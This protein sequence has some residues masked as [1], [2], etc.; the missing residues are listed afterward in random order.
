MSKEKWKTEM[1]RTPFQ[2]ALWNPHECWQLKIM[3][4]AFDFSIPVYINQSKGQFRSESAH[5]PL[6]QPSAISL[7][8]G[9]WANL[10]VSPGEV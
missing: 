9:L 4:D 7:S 2:L 5:I 10:T 8:L 6:I 1:Q 3:T